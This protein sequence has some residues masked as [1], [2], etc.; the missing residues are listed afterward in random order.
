[1]LIF[2]VK[3]SSVDCTSLTQEHSHLLSHQILLLLPFTLFSFSGSPM[4]M[5]LNLPL[6]SLD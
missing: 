1:M 6:K 5:A 3:F 4:L 2:E